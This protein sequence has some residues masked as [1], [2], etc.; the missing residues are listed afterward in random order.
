M[1]TCSSTLRFSHEF[2]CVVLVNGSGDGRRYSTT[3][4]MLIPELVDIRLWTIQPVLARY[5]HTMIFQSSITW[6]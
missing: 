5:F 3:G 1:H 6:F 4:A 2:Q